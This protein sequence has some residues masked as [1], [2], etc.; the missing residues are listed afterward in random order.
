MPEFSELLMLESPKDILYLSDMQTYELYFL[1]LTRGGKRSYINMKGLGCR[2]Y[3]MLQGRTEPCPFCT[4][5]LLVKDQ[6]NIW[7]HH[8][9]RTGEEYFLRDKLIE[10]NGSPVRMELAMDVSDPER[11]DSIIQ[12]SMQC[13]NLLA[14]CIQPLSA[15]LGLREAF[16]FALERTGDFF[17]TDSGYVYCYDGPLP[18]TVWSAGPDGPVLFGEELSKDGME[19]W[20]ERLQRQGHRQVILRDVE[21]IAGENREVYRFLKEMGIF[22]LCATPIFVG[23]R[24]GWPVLPLQCP[25]PSERF[26]CTERRGRLSLRPDSEGGAPPGEGEGPVL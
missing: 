16:Q 6:Y 26:G 1:S 24:A 17:G 23:E 21:D 14:S 10:R 11:I 19:R 25:G 3:E 15:E 2:C 13:Q 18:N 20:K 22:S 9:Q 7:R 12:N 8:N 4:N 5:H